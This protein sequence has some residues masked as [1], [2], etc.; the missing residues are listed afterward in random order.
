MSR[1]RQH[2]YRKPVTNPLSADDGTSRFTFNAASGSFTMAAI[3][4]ALRSSQFAG[5]CIRALT[6][7]ANAVPYIRSYSSQTKSPT[8]KNHLLTAIFILCTASIALA[9]AEKHDLALELYAK[10]GLEAQMQTIPQTVQESY[11]AVLEQKKERTDFDKLVGENIAWL[12]AKAYDTEA[13]TN[14]LLK[15]IGEGM[16]SLEI[17]QVLAWLDSPLGQKCTRLEMLASAP[18]EIDSLEEFMANT[19]WPAI[20]GKRI[21]LLHALDEAAGITGAAV[22]ININTQFAVSYMTISAMAPMSRQ[23][24]EQLYERINAMRGPLQIALQSSIMNS[25]LYTYS[26]LSDEELA[27][28]VDF[29]SSDIGT[30]YH[31]VTSGGFQRAISNGSLELGRLIAGLVS[32]AHGKSFSDV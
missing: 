11:L 25:L 23:E 19:D 15:D 3:A 27:G 6:T 26:G 10:S 14:V 16:T 22:N 18:G 29:A 20:P 4:G 30:K 1:H 12:V 32:R 13:I 24:S 21:E 31:E 9:G 2:L 17:N 8:M 7:G 28:Y 5:R